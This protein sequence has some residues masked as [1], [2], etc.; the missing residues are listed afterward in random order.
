M[1]DL[2]DHNLNSEAVNAEV[3]PAESIA[4]SPKPKKQKPEVTV[5][6]LHKDHGAISFLDQIIPGSFYLI[7]V[8][9]YRKCQF[10][11]VALR[12]VLRFT[13]ENDAI[14]LINK[15]PLLSDFVIFSGYELS[16]KFKNQYNRLQSVAFK[17]KNK[18]V[19]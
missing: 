13:E 6:S 9:S 7:D 2:T 4:P 1:L 15:T 18:K 3:P 12:G 19:A 11:E 10:E 16:S 14:D 8:E 17:N 5:E